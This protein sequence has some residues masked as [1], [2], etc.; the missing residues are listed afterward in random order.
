MSSEQPPKVT[1][2]AQ[3][4]AR[5]LVLRLLAAESCPGIGH[6]AVA[7]RIPQRCHL[8]GQVPQSVTD[9]SQEFFA[10][11]VAGDQGDLT[12]AVCEE[13]QTAMEE[14]KDLIKPVA[15]DSIRRAVAGLLTNETQ[16]S[17]RN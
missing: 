5:V 11:L 3:R 14:A 15:A 8:C 17:E 1:E 9:A 16:A 4:L 2:Q 6:Q 10:A 7:T 12:L 13:L